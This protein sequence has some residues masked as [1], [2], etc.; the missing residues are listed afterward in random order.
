M[1]AMPKPTFKEFKPLQPFI[2]NETGERLCI[3]T[4]HTRLPRVAFHS[5]LASHSEHQ[6]REIGL[7]HLFLPTVDCA[8]G[9]CRATISKT[10][11]VIK[12]GFDTLFLL[13]EPKIDIRYLVPTEVGMEGALSQGCTIAPPQVRMAACGFMQVLLYEGGLIGSLHSH[14]F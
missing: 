14:S 8:T 10:T 2:W 12:E 5:N 11:K 9:L 7:R 3:S 13:Q 4:V 1:A 6:L